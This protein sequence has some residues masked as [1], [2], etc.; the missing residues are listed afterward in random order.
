MKPCSNNFCGGN[1]KDWLEVYLTSECNGCCPW[2]VDVGGI[3]VKDSTAEKITREAIFYGAKNIILLGGEPTLYPELKYVIDELNSFNRNVYL[4]TNGSLLT[5]EF[6]KNLENLTGINISIHHYDLRKNQ[7]ITGIDLDFNNLKESIS[8][9]K[10]NKT[11]IRL[12]CNCIAGYIDSKQ[13][14]LSYIDFAK[15][16]CVDAIRFAELK[17]DKKSFVNLATIFE[18]EFGLNNDP[19]SLGC[20]FITKINGMTVYFRQ[21]CGLQTEHRT[22]ITEPEQIIKKVLYND[23]IVREGWQ[24]D[25]AINSINSGCCY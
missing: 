16:L 12:N 21:M 2:C 25:G 19:Y 14:T 5:P 23:A 17:G 6:I 13:E 22:A 18:N 1:F 4:T 3:R 11:I 9:L 7:E 15:E 10:N 24:Y 8:L 20:N